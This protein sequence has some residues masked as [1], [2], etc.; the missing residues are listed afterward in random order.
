MSLER[1]EVRLLHHC[2]LVA[3]ISARRVSAEFSQTVSL[4]VS[5]DLIFFGNDLSK[6]KSHFKKS[7][8][9]WK[10][11]TMYVQNTVN[12]RISAEDFLSVK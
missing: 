3:C 1:S 7:L 10:M 11:L 9:K 8:K 5:N 4:A 6:V 12:P 2:I